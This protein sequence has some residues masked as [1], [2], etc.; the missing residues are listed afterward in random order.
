MTML[1]AA[2]FV[3]LGLVLFL[4]PSWSADELPW[5]VSPFLA[6][7]LGAWYLGT[8][9]FAVAAARER[10][11]DIEHGVLIY[12]WAFSLGQAALLV[13][14]SDVLTFDGRVLAVPYVAALVTA[15]ATALVGI[16]DVAR[17]RPAFRDD[18]TRV[19]R[20]IRLSGAAFVVAVALLALPLVDGYDSPQSIWP[21]E[22]TLLSARSFSVFFGSLSL[23]AAV[24]LA[25]GSANAVAAYLR[26]GLVLNVLILVAALVYHERFDVGDHPGQLLYIGLY[27][28]VLV[29]ALLALVRT[30][31]RAA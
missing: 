16:A 17:A 3:A 10:R 4:A 11:W 26:A 9:V 2:A 7:T 27:V 20:W 28:L 12:L 19:A 29:L 22:L 1:T 18:G 6:M 15:A 23:S 8:G 5:S 21:G 13:I 24:V 25:V 30:R 31:R 14:H